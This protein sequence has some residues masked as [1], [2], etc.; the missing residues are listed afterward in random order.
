MHCKDLVVADQVLGAR[1]NTET[2][3]VVSWPVGIL[4]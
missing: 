3:S 4:F 2:E 1:G